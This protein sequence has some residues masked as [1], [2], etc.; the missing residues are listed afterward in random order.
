MG[1]CIVAN[2]CGRGRK[3]FLSIAPPKPHARAPTKPDSG[4]CCGCT[5][6]RIYISRAACAPCVCVCLSCVCALFLPCG[7]PLSLLLDSFLAVLCVYISCLCSWYVPVRASS[8]VFLS[9]LLILGINAGIAAECL[10]RRRTAT[11]G[12][13]RRNTPAHMPSL[14]PHLDC[15][16]DY[17]CQI[18][19]TP[20]AADS[21]TLYT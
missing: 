14:L 19:M 21:R 16:T 13:T 6:I 8:I 17:A 12:N 3:P 2:I 11:A 10:W 20:E 18:V 1:R 9:W 4:A 5:L 7:P 15:C